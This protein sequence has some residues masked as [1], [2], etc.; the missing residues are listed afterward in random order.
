MVY[1]C[2]F[3]MDQLKVTVHRAITYPVFWKEGV[4]ISTH[5]PDTKTEFV[6]FAVS[7]RENAQVLPCVNNSVIIMIH[8][9]AEVY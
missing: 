6:Q 5:S 1:F 4:Q 3:N 2:N 8:L 9:R 7:G